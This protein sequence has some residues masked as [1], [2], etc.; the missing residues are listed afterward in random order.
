M[1]NRLDAVEGKAAVIQTGIGVDLQ[2]TGAQL[3]SRKSRG[4][5]GFLAVSGI[6][7]PQ[8]AAFC[9]LAVMDFADAEKAGMDMIHLTEPSAAVNENAAV[10]VAVDGENAFFSGGDEIQRAEKIVNAVGTGIRQRAI[11]RD[12]NEGNVDFPQHKG[13]EIHGIGQRIRAVGHNDAVVGTEIHFAEFRRQ[14]FQTGNRHILAEDAERP[15]FF[16]NK[17]FPPHLFRHGLIIKN[18]A[19]TDAAK[20][21]FFEIRGEGA[22]G[23]DH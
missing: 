18:R 15:P 8:K 14:R 13:G 11:R 22:A 16:E 20:T 2:N 3:R 5:F 10:A 4:G 12:K 7:I 1:E 21:V 19:V 17:V 9:D 23:L 6:F